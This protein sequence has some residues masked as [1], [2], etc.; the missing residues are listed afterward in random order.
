MN[1]RDVLAKWLFAQYDKQYGG[2]SVEAFLG[3][4]DAIIE[5]LAAAGFKVV[6]REFDTADMAFAESGQWGRCRRKPR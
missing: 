3:D 1:A 4:A 5:D 6:A 2:Q